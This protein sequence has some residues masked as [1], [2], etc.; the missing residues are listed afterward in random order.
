MR[1]KKKVYRLVALKLY[2]FTNEF[3]AVKLQKFTA[4]KKCPIYVR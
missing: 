2:N 4:L 3:G 1:L